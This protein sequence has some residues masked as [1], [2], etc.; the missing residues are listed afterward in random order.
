MQV[1]VLI[2]ANTPTGNQAIVITVGTANTQ[3]G[4][5]VAVQ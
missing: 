1:N 5:T 2:P 4:V 3:T